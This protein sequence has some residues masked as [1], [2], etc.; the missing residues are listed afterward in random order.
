V[1]ARGT[2]DLAYRDIRQEHDMTEQSADHSVAR[3]TLLCGGAVAAGAAGALVLST[4]RPPRAEAADGDPVLLGRAQSGLTT[5]TLRVEGESR[6]SESTLALLNANGPSLFLQPLASDWDGE[7]A[8]GAV[9]N[10]AVGPLVGVEADASSAVTTYLATGL[11]LDALPLPVAT[12]PSRLLDTRISAGRSNIL[13][14]STGAFDSSQRL[15]AGAWIDIAVNAANQDFTLAAAF[16]N[17]TSTQSAGNGYLT[18]C[19]PGPKPASS[20]LNFTNGVTIANAAFIGLGVV[21]TYFAVRIY[22]SNSTHVILDLTGATVSNQPGPA[23]QAARSQKAAALK[24]R[25]TRALS[26]S[27]EALG[28]GRR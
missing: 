7:L 1:E 11:D 5:T 22:A 12:T 26:R 19:P 3:R 4:V 23:S 20:S 28:G 24:Q 13:R 25:Q 10:T 9:A 8:V 6:N 2:F 14:S 21:D 27:A 17:L 16:L 15:K 18:I